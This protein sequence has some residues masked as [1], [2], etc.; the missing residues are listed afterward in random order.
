MITITHVSGPLAGQSQ[1]FDDTK[2]KIEF[3]RELGSDVVYPEDTDIVGHRHFAL[4]HEDGDWLLHL[5]ESSHGTPHV[6]FVNGTPGDTGQS[7]N[8]NSV[9]HLGRKDGPG[10][11]FKFDP[12]GL[13]E[14]ALRTR[15][16]AKVSS[17][18]DLYRRLAVTGGVV[19]ALLIVVIGG[20]IA[21]NIA[22]EKQTAAT[23]ASLAKDQQNAAA[24]IANMR[25]AAVA[26]FSPSAIDHLVRAT[27]LVYKQDAQG[28]QFADGTAWV[29]GP[30]LLATN[31]HIAAL[32]SDFQ[33]G[34]DKLASCDQIDA[35]QKLYVRQPGAGGAS[36]EVIGHSFHPGYV[37][38]PRFV[39]AKDP[40]ISTFAGP[41]QVGTDGYDVGLLR[42]KG[43]LPADLALQVAS[44]EEMMEL[45]LGAPLASAGYPSENI[46]NSEVLTVAATPQVHYGNISALTDFALSTDRCRA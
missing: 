28:R 15:V 29:I 9:F 34:D 30:D 8:P 13:D 36:Y 17:T 33:P 10:F 24:A 23:F 21:K 44:K 42:I 27:F 45:K 41:R 20:W 18:R 39:L 26:S 4:K 25:T 14:G 5:H 31:A 32:C 46:F 19:A 40:V 37:A 22:D 1:T 35:G 43:Q 2:S 3:G 16:E 38:F 6:V 7:I 11:S 12:V